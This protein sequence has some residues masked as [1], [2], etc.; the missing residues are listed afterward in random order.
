M[1]PGSLPPLGV[2]HRVAREAR[3]AWLRVKQPQPPSQSQSQS[4]SQ[5]SDSADSAS[6]PIQWP[7]S[8]AATRRRLKEL[9]KRKYSIA[10]H[11]QRLLQSRSPSPPPDMFSNYTTAATPAPFTRDLGISLVSGTL[12]SDP[13]EAASTPNIVSNTVHPITATDDDIPRLGSPFMYH[14]WGPSTSRNRVTQADTTPVQGGVE[15][16]DT[17]HVTGSRLRSGMPPDL[18]TPNNQHLPAVPVPGPADAKE[19]TPHRVRIR[20]RTRGLTTNSSSSSNMLNINSRHRLIQLFT[21]PSGSGSASN[22]MDDPASH[23]RSQGLEAEGE[24]IK[25]LGSPF[26]LDLPASKRPQQQ[27]RQYHRP[28]HAPSRSDT[29]LMHPHAHTQGQLHFSNLSSTADIDTSDTER[30]APATTL[31]SPAA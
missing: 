13:P 31:N 30:P 8:D 14:T 18:F 11:Y 6:R 26:N 29:F 7:R 17:V 28:R 19:N 5:P 1:L 15:A 23:G 22:E 4:Q 16:H 12:P 27:P 20:T 24:G 9:C 10:P 21:P 25:R 2:S 3:R